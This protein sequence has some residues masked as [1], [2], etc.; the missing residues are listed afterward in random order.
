MLWTEDGPHFVDLDDART[1]PAVQDLWMLLSGDRATMGAS[2]RRAARLRGFHR[3]STARA[4]SVEPLRTLRLIHY[5]AGSPAAG[6]IPA[7]PAAFPWF[8]TQRYWQDRI[9][10]LREQIA[11]M[12]E[13]PLN[14]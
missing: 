7:F 12:E 9:L 4:A 14:P 11:L 1:G 3:D 5:S 13:E 6:T 2:L 10:E 8:N